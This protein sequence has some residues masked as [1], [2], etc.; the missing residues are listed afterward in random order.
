MRL[1]IL[2]ALVLSTLL[3]SPVWADD[4]TV[5]RFQEA[6]DDRSYDFTM[7]YVVVNATVGKTPVRL[8]ANDF[9]YGV[10]KG[11]LNVGQI[12]IVPE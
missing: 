7:M 10:G 4:V 3:T 9:S 12:E 6:T 1:F 8:E 2:V 5:G 11:F